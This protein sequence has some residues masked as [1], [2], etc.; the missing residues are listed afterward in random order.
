M[1]RVDNEP[2]QIDT[3][4]SHLNPMI[5]S[6]LLLPIVDYKDAKRIW[7]PFEPSSAISM[8]HAYENYYQF[9]IKGPAPAVLG[10]EI[11]WNNR[12]EYTVPKADESIALKMDGMMSV[13]AYHY[14]KN[15]G[16]NVSPFTVA[17]D[18]DTY[19]EVKKWLKKSKV[20]DARPILIDYGAY[21]E[22]VINMDH[23]E[24]WIA[25]TIASTKA[26]IV[27]LPIPPA[28]ISNYIPDRT[29]EMFHSGSNWLSKCLERRVVIE[30]PFQPNKT[31]IQLINEIMDDLK[32]NESMI[33]NSI[34]CKCGNCF[35]C[36]MTHV[37]LN[38]FEIKP[39]S[40][41]PETFKDSEFV[42][43]IKKLIE[44]GKLNG[45]FVD[46]IRDFIGE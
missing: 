23:Y 46:E 19:G 24:N 7:I 33:I 5:A 18:K 2:I 12:I 36:F 39:P 25:S 20:K 29:H 27:W 26:D 4:V 38:H 16:I 11:E 1:G 22:K 10:L 32:W 40:D 43:R 3:N 41:F 34:K 30:T 42:R 15:K 17:Y 6:A 13:F 35:E 28:E 31:R 37:V 8:T 14:F 9:L 21:K 45:S 44:L